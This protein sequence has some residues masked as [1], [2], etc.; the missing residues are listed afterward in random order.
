MAYITFIMIIRL[1]PGHRF[2]FITWEQLEK[3]LPIW[4]DIEDK[5]LTWEQLQAYVEP[6]TQP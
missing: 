5:Q 1:A 2:W 4:Q 6:G 3:R